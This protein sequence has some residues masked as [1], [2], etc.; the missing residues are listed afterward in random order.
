MMPFCIAAC[1]LEV[2]LFIPL[3]ALWNGTCSSL[4][5]LCGTLF[6]SA[7]QDLASDDAVYYSVVVGFFALFWVCAADH[8]EWQS[9]V[10]LKR[11]KVE[12]VKIST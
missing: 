4:Y 1:S 8:E 2:C 7:A 10:F 12:T 11:V 3:G 5:K 6:I 9:I